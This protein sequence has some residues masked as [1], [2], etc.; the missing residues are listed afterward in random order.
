MDINKLQE[1]IEKVRQLGMRNDAL[2]KENRLL[3]T[4]NEGLKLKIETKN[5]D[6]NALIQE[7]DEFQGNVNDNVSVQQ[8]SGANN[9]NKLKKE[10]DQYI[11]EINQCIEWLNAN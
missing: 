9:M 10:I 11:G 5:I 4:E 7:I 3:K 6:I 8:S 1:I 2:L